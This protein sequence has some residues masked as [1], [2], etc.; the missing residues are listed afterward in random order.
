[1]SE[2]ATTPNKKRTKR[3]FAQVVIDDLAK[4]AFCLEREKNPVIRSPKWAKMKKDT[5]IPD[6]RAP[7]RDWIESKQ[8]RILRVYLASKLAP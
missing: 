5:S 7:R 3:T 1:M 8:V 2:K 4:A 6:F